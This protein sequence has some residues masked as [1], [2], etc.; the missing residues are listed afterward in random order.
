VTRTISAIFRISVDVLQ[1]DR[2]GRETA[3]LPIVA[4]SNLTR[5]LPTDPDY[6]LWARSVCPPEGWWQW[7]GP[8]GV[9]RITTC[10]DCTPPVARDLKAVI[11]KM[12]TARRGPF[13]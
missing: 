3:A 4:E 7:D 13:E 9:G 8:A 12:R 10:N 2:C 1:C 11:D 5:G 6:E